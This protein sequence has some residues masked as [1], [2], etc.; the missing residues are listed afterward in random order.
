MK[1]NCIPDYGSYADFT[2]Y[3]ENSSIT[4]DTDYAGNQYYLNNNSITDLANYAHLNTRYT[5]ITD[6]ADLRWLNPTHKNNFTSDYA[7]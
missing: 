6:C 1:N 7:N 2:D 5:F 3:V 4:N